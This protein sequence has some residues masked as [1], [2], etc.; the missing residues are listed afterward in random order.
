MKA[1]C[2]PLKAEMQLWG[3][4]GLTLPIWWR[5]DDAIEPT[6]ALDRLIALSQELQIP[7]HLAVIP[8]MAT[9]AL[10][11]TVAKT[12]C[13]TPVVYGWAHL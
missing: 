9:P 13:L 10:A 8:E 1:D 5:D 6:G 12:D 4:A 11:A 7:V 2:S 3:D